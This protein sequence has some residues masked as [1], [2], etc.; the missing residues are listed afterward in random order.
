MKKLI[1]TLLIG[2]VLLIS[3]GTTGGGSGTGLTLQNAIEQ[4]ADK[5][6]EELPR[7]NHVAVVAFESANDNLSEH[8]MRELDGALFD[9]GVNTVERQNLAVAFREL[10]FHMSGYVSDETAR[11][12]GQMIGADIVITGQLTGFGGVYRY[13]TIAINVETAAR[14]SITRFDV[15]NDRE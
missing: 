10:D 3:C 2:L 14:V 7:G 1:T 15:Q 11:S 5:I 4:S 6:A 8:I 12:I 9:R 13:R